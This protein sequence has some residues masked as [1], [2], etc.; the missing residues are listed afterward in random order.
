[1]IIYY[2]G[3]IQNDLDELNELQKSFN[4]YISGQNDTFYLIMGVFDHFFLL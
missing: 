4:S 3:Y 1:M 2:I